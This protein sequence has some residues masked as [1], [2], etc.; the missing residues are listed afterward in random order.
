MNND[1]FISPIKP[2][3]GKVVLNSKSKWFWLAITIAV[4]NPIICGVI[5]GITLWTEPKYRKQAKLILVISVVWGVAL[6][7][8]SNWLIERGY[9]PYY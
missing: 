4:L 1:N 7:Y 5:L 3:E 6:I 9:L 8:L 2:E